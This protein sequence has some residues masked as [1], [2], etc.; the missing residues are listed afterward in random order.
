MVEVGEKEQRRA[1]VAA[2]ADILWTAGEE[3]TATISLV[4]SERCFTPHLDY[5]LDSF[6]ERVRADT[7]NQ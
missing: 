3:Q 4:T 5:K 7:S 2:L 6:T 1:L